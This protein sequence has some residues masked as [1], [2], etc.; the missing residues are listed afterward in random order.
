[1]SL[2]FSENEIYNKKYTE[3]KSNL[4]KETMINW[5]YIKIFYNYLGCETVPTSKNEFEK[6]SAI[7]FGHTPRHLPTFKIGL[8]QIWK[9][10]VSPEW[11]WILQNF[12]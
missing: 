8:L 4:L 5:L 3:E 7:Y 12:L 6:F 10:N 9:W 1:M 11:Q 2:S